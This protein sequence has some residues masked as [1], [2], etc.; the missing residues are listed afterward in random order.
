MRMRVAW[1]LC[2]LTL[3]LGG[4]IGA[5]PQRDFLSDDEADQVRAAQD[6]NERLVCY[7]KF[8]RL[9]LE[10]VKQALV[11]EKPGRSKII[12]DNLEDYTH[13]VEAMD[14]V[15][16]DALARKLDLTKG[17][18]MLAEREK[19]FLTTLQEFAARPAKDR[20]YFEFALKDATEAT[21]DSLEESQHDLR[22]RARRVLEEDVREK[23]KREAAMTP[24][25]LE[26][27]KAEEKQADEKAKKTP[28]APTL[29]RK[30]E[31]PKDK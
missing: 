15:I 27:H 2:L 28:K 17:V 19:E 6:P 5:G 30:G 3:L 14:A 29:R 8:A 26:K 31:V 18:A 25:E 20:H 22:E 1:R 24:A 23:K 7:L 11:A 21:Q 10:L 4:A 9:R 12:H 13:I 16:D